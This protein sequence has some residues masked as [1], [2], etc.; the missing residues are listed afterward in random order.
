MRFPIST[1]YIVKSSLSV[2]I[3]LFCLHCS[4]AAETEPT[5]GSEEST[6]IDLIS[7]TADNP[8]SLDLSQQGFQSTLDN[9]V[10]AVALPTPHESTAAEWI[11]RLDRAIVSFINKAD[12]LYA[13]ATDLRFKSDL[14]RGLIRLRAIW[15]GK[16]R[17]V[18]QIASGAQLDSSRRAAMEAA[19]RLQLFGLPDPT[20]LTDLPE[21]AF[22][23][24]KK[25]YQRHQDALLASQ[26]T[27]RITLIRRQSIRQLERVLILR[28]S[29]KAVL[30]DAQAREKLLQILSSSE[31][32][33]DAIWLEVVK[34]RGMPDELPV[35]HIIP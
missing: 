6:L 2:T 23:T 1:S 28:I 10:S 27:H 35:R 16:L 26:L 14:T 21:P 31:A 12:V 29:D 20:T 24:Y 34:N 15:Q 17:V 4:C 11:W 13:D 8:D 32:S 30:T 9:L 22:E 5:S 7:Q 19:A 33:V 3:M 18:E 25:A